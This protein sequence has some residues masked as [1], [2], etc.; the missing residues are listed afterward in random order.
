M[1]VLE[2]QG[3]Q[4]GCEPVQRKLLYLLEQTKNRPPT[5]AR[6]VGVSAV[7]VS[8]KSGKTTLWVDIDELRIL[9]RCT[10]VIFDIMGDNSVSSFTDFS[11]VVQGWF[12]DQIM[13][14]F[15]KI[16]HSNTNK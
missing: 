8:S 10:V 9:K 7:A 15:H 11:A 1:G 3:E 12:Y 6:C 16:S 5:D 13:F 4:L 14:A 2:Q